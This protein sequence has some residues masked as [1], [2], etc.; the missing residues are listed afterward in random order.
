MSNLSLKGSAPKL[1]EIIDKFDNA[2]FEWDDV[3]DAA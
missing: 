3:D 1:E 2:G